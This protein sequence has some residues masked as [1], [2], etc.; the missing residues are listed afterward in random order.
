MKE[1]KYQVHKF[2]GACLANPS[3]VHQA[4][5][6][7][8]KEMQ[9]SE[10]K[11]IIVVSAALGV[12]DTIRNG[13]KNLFTSMTIVHDTI[14]ELESL[15]NQFTEV[16]P[17]LKPVYKE[18]SEK[19]DNLLLK[20][21][22]K[23]NLSKE[24]RDLCLITGERFMAKAMVEFLASHSLEANCLMPE[25]IEF[26]TDG[27]FFKAEVDFSHDFSKFKSIIAETT[28]KTR[29]IVIPGFY[30]INKEGK[31]TTFGPSGTDYSATSIANILNA[32]KTIIWKDVNGF[33]TSDPRLVNSQTIDNLGY[34]EAAE[35]AHFGAKVLHP[36]AVLP[37][38]IKQ[39]PIE[40]RNVNNNVK[41]LIVPDDKTDV[42]A[43][44]S[45]SYM[46]DVGLLKVYISSG[47]TQYNV[48]NNIYQTFSDYHINIYA[49]ATSST[50]ITF[51]LNQS[52]LE[53]VSKL[54]P[55]QHPFIEKIE[56]IT[57]ICL[58]CLVGKGLGTTP[59]I[60]SQIFSVVGNN[61]INVEMITAGASP[62]ALQFTVK[63]NKLEEALSHL[64]NY[65]FE[66][67]VK[68]LVNLA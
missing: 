43:V 38:Q 54:L 41:S 2:G 29:I 14:N 62:V 22:E 50:A 53:F 34:S 49:I 10:D 30:G 25:D 37:A 16:F 39:I 64:H 17:S 32:E 4:V 42:Q 51:L 40:I 1:R 65:F 44:K 47:G 36:R 60:A 55:Q 58:I 28:D 61:G 21:V 20:S 46:K 56:I 19:L 12:T 57:D 9:N 8:I 15:H 18:L 13:I 52:E 68:K 6:C 5:S 33:M 63:Q 66:D 3:K 67:E 31:I 24:D 11:I 48:I 26:L 23:N 27:K 7:I 45:I 59:N 35:L